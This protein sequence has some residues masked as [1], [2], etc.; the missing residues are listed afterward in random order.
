MIS[1]H[2]RVPVAY[3][4]AAVLRARILNGTYPP[5]ALLPSE[6]RLSQEHGVGRG[7]VRRAVAELRAEGLVDAA[8]GRGTRVREAADREI[9]SVPRGALVSARMPTPE[10]RAE[11]DIPE[12]VPVQVVTLGG[13]VRGVHPADRVTLRLR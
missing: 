1:P 10:E 12:G 8:S 7:T 9:V 6:T 3:Q 11:L 2:T 5:G 13:R 4:L